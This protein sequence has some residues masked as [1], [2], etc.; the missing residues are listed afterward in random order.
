MQK[1]IKTR[2]IHQNLQIGSEPELLIAGQFLSCK[3]TRKSAFAEEISLCFAASSQ[4]SLD[5]LPHLMTRWPSEP[6]PCLSCCR[7]WMP[8]TLGRI[9]SLELSLLNSK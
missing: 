5:S 2:K 3:N 7:S 9:V 1:H 8:P 4:D 6:S